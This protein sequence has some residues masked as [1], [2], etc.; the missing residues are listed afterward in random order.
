MFIFSLPGLSVA[1]FKA[2]YRETGPP[3]QCDW[4]F[5]PFPTMVNEVAPWHVINN[6]S[7]TIPAI[8]VLC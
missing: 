2:S 4:L 8:K 1:Y 6:I 5:H 7:N 3:Q